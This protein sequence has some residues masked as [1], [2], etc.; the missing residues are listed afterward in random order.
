MPADARPEYR[1]QLLPCGIAWNIEQGA[2]GVA[3]GAREAHI[4]DPNAAGSWRQIGEQDAGQ[5]S[6]PPRQ[7]GL[8]DCDR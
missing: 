2:H 5:K 4:L 3:L 7:S 8:I 6:E 1:A